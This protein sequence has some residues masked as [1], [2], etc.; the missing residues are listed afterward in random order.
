[1]TKAIGYIRVS[2]EKQADH[3]VSLEAQEAKLRAYADLYGIEL[4]RVIVDAG[5]SAKT[6]KRE[7]LQEALSS[8][9]SGESDALLV[10]TLDRLTRSVRDLGELVE[11]YFADDRSALLSVSEQIDTRSAGGR[12][13]LNVLMSVSQWEREAIGERTAAALAHKKS[14]NEYC[15]GKVPF[16]WTL[17]DGELEE[18]ATEREIIAKARAL[19]TAGY[20]FN[21]T[22]RVLSERGYRTRTGRVFAAQQVKNMLEAA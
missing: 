8:L 6:L 11:K 4:V 20:S 5:A 15:G 3:G 16:G 7:G 17:V 22:A 9:V 2:T 21:K 13:V 10:C 12:L 18:N 1:M 19:T 14:R